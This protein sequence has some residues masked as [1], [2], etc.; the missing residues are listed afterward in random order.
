LV[1]LDGRITFVS[2]GTQDPAERLPVPSAVYENSETD[3]DDFK[4]SQKAGLRRYATSKLCNIYCT[5]ELSRRLS[6]AGSAP[7]LQESF[8][9]SGSA[10]GRL[11]MAGALHDESPSGI[12]FRT[13]QPRLG[14]V[15]FCSRR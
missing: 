3:A 11:I 7:P 4:S 2:N 6:A 1:A 9:A 12:G 15:R 14:S 5:Y 8:A 10:S 13:S